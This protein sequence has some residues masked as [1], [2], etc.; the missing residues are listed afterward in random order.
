MI[1]SS[2]GAFLFG[3]C[4]LNSSYNEN[5]YVEILLHYRLLFVK[6][7]AFI[8]EWGILVQRFPFVTANF[9]LKVTSL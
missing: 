6:G 1:L 5:K 2:R 8:G 3:V 7:N 9:L 4:T